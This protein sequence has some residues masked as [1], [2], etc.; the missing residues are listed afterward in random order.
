MVDQA[1]ISENVIAF[2]E[3]QN[4]VQ[5]DGDLDYN[6]LSILNSETHV[7]GE[8]QSAHLQLDQQVLCHPDSS[9]FFASFNAV[10]AEDDVRPVIEFAV[11]GSMIDA[12]IL[13]RLLMS[14]VAG[15]VN[16]EVCQNADAS[17]CLVAVCSQIV[18]NDVVLMCVMQSS[19]DSSGVMEAAISNG[20][21]TIHGFGALRSELGVWSL[22]EK[23]ERVVCR[24]DMNALLLAVNPE[25][26]VEEEEQQEV[27]EEE[28]QEEVVEQEEEQEEDVVEE[29]EEQE[30]EVVEEKEEQQEA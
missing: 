15:D 23:I 27:V 28:Q 14:S 1:T 21:S 30:E 8:M 26:V 18:A 9:G 19:C 3:N 4:M 6:V 17:N 2:L 12:T 20:L 16:Y 24:I 7:P 22:C 5:V 29:K 25:A 11:P 13:C 10:M